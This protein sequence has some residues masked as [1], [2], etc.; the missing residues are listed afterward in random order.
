MYIILT[1]QTQEMIKN[2]LSTK[3]ILMS[4]RDGARLTQK[5]S[6]DYG[7]PILKAVNLEQEDSQSSMLYILE[8][9]IILTTH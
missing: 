1:T 2:C 6:V 5:S 4:H 9:L 3:I 7:P 8:K